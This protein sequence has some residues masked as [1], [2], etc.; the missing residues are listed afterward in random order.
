MKY[1]LKFILIV[2]VSTNANA[3]P[4]IPLGQN[5]NGEAAGDQS[6]YSVSI[7]S[8][9]TRVAIGAIGN[10]DNRGQVRV[11]AWNGNGSNWIQLGDDIDGEATGD[12]S[13]R[14]VSLSSDGNRLAIGAVFNAGNGNNAGHVR[15]YDWN[16]T[17]WLQTGQDIDGQAMGDLCGWSSSFSS[18]GNRIAIGSEANGNSGNNAGHVRIFDWNGVEWVQVGQDING[19]AAEDQS[20][21]SVRLSADG[22]RVAIDARAN[23]GN[24]NNAGHVRVF[25]WNGSAWAQVGEDIDGEAASDLSGSSIS[26]SA[27]GS[28]VA[29]GATYNG[30]IGP[31]AGHVRIYDWNGTAWLQTGQDID[32]EATGDFSGSSVSLS[33]DG[34]LLAIGSSYNDGPSANNVNSGHIRVF[35]WSGT[36]WI[37][38]GQDIDGENEGDDFGGSVSL[39]ASGSRLV[40]GAWLN[41]GNGIHSGHVRI[42]QSG[43]LL[44]SGKIYQDYDL[45]HEIDPGEPLL[46][47]QLVQLSSSTGDTK[48]KTTTVNGEYYFNSEDSGTY[49][50]SYYPPISWM[51]TGGVEEYVLQSINDTIVS[52]L[53]FGIGY[54]DTIVDLETDLTLLSETQFGPNFQGWVSTSNSGNVTTGLGTLVSGSGT[55]TVTAFT[56]SNSTVQP[57]QITSDLISW[58]QTAS[59]TTTVSVDLVELQL[60]QP[61]NLNY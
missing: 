55:T 1:L 22:N 51:E 59:V 23:D 4:W 9:G 13:G 20:G 11:Y 27:D 45:D 34:N 60:L 32:G 29:I 46:D 19:E 21:R 8:D 18:D 5:I 53:D 6:G 14:S 35:S 61:Q 33:S 17:A 39:S 31:Y 30:G 2:L 42:Y 41:D 16:G 26:L 54:T 36:E 10:D 52:G 25:D 12:E 37:Q 49:T 58:S 38:Q 15:V 3:Q 7:S 50:V 28:R 47:G 24:G 44:I 40:G 56:Q 43:G 57:G 48:Y